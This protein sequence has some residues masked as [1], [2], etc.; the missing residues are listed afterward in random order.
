MNFK[1]H[2]FLKK[3]ECAKNTKK[4]C[5]SACA[6]MPD[7]VCDNVT[8]DKLNFM[9]YFDDKDNGRKWVKLQ[10]QIYKIILKSKNEVNFF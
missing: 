6:P 9:S 7:Y 2:Q 5:K 3:Q 10:I 4:P 1:F 8:P